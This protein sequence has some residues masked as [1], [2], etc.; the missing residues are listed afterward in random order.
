MT[1][2]KV[3][4]RLSSIARLKGES[5]TTHTLDASCACN[6]LVGIDRHPV[7]GNVSAPTVLTHR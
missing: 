3:I 6:P 4:N 5:I 7:Y 2:L 1:E